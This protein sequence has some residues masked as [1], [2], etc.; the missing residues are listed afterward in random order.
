METTRASENAL[1]SDD[2]DG[3]ITEVRSMTQDE[4]ESFA[5]ELL[6]TVERAL[7][8]EKA[9]SEQNRPEVPIEVTVVD[10]SDAPLI[11]PDTIENRKDY[12]EYLILTLVFDKWIV[13]YNKLPDNQ[14]RYL[15]YPELTFG[16]ILAHLR[17]SI[18]ISW[19]T[20]LYMYVDDKLI[21]VTQTVEE[22]VRRSGIANKILIVH[23][24]AET[25]FG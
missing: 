1:N 22:L 19:L 13:D 2:S 16:Q 8:N 4:V 5:N 17:G 12:V 9:R 25:T 23:V 24:L 11:V 10:K 18:K 15:V 20:G 7:L 21:S 3:E 6:E 14:I